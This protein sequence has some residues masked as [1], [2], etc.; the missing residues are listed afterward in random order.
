[1]TKKSLRILLLIVLLFASASVGQNVRSGYC[2]EST[3]P[4]VNQMPTHNHLVN[5][6]SE[7]ASSAS[8]DSTTNSLS[9]DAWIFALI[10]AWI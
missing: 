3:T 6:F 8:P 1:M 4:T 10:D 2:D 5:D 7:D 9:L